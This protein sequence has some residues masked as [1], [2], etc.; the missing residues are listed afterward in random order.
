MTEQQTERILLA[1][2]RVGQHV[3]ALNVLSNCG[4][5]CV[6][7]GLNPRS[8]GGQRML[9][10]GHIKPWKDSSPVERLDLRNGLAACPSH[11]VAF[12]TGLLTVDAGLQIRASTAL[13]GA[14][15]ADPLA[16]Q[17]YGRRLS[18]TRFS[19]RPAPSRPPRNTS[20]GTG[21]TSSPPEPEARDSRAPR[22]VPA[23]DLKPGVRARAE[24]DL[25]A[26]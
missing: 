6:F 13:A 25:V 7:C 3:F 21:P 14:V 15:R 11:D 9:V 1:A 20:T 22:L 18:S 5:R 16:R 19:S 8:F 24:R 23:S 4:Q 2:A 12:D 10:A 26:L 17:Y